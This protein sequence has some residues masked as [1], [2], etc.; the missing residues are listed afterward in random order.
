MQ[1]PKCGGSLVYYEVQTHTWELGD[2]DR[3]AW[4]EENDTN[5]LDAGVECR[6]CGSKFSFERTEAGCDEKH[7]K[8]VLT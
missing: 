1:C 7:A 4:D 5:C 8:I 3:L 2:E 6:A